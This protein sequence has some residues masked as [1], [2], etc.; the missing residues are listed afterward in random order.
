MF[1]CTRRLA[2]H[3]FLH[4]LSEDRGVAV[5]ILGFSLRRH[6]CHIVKWGEK[7][8][9]IHGVEVHEAFQFEIHGV[10]G[11]S[12]VAGLSAEKILGATAEARDMPG[13]SG[14]RNS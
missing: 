9:S 1:T 2:D 6:Q 7:N 11:L 3:E 13:Q 5:D 4:C 10:M 12:A 14:I 8:S